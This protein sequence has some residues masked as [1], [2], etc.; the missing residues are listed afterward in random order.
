VPRRAD[1]SRVVAG[2]LHATLPPLSWNVL[3]LA[4]ARS[5]D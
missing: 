3:R 4:P 1:G 2:A 5:T